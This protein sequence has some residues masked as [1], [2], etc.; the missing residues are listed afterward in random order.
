MNF[1]ARYENFEGLRIRI[2]YISQPSAIFD[3]ASTTVIP[4]T[5]IVHKACAILYG[6]ILN[7]NKA[8]RDKYERSEMRHMNIA[9]QYKVAN[10]WRMPQSTVWLPDDPAASASSSPNVMEW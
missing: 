3:D 9:E 1:V 10:K 7:D 8:D 4:K 6:S 2:Q 5:Y